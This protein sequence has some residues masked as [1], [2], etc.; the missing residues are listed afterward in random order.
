[1][2]LL[3][4]IGLFLWLPIW[5]FPFTDTALLLNKPENANIALSFWILIIIGTILFFIGF[6]AMIKNITIK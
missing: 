2:R 6:I 3:M 5:I 4:F 1:M